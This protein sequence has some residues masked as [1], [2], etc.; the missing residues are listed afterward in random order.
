VSIVERAL[1]TTLSRTGSAVPRLV[2]GGGPARRRRI[3]FGLILPVALVILWEAACRVGFIAPNQ[4]PAPTAVLQDMAAMAA[5]GELFDHIGITLYRVFV[6]FLLGVAAATVLGSLTGY[7]R[8][9]RELLDPL[10]QAL[11]NVPSLAWVPLFILWLGIYELSKVTLI[12]AGV[13]F[14]VYLNLMSGIQGVDRKLV[15]VGRVYR[16]SGLKLIRRVL[17]PATLPSYLVGLRSGLGL[18]WMF[19]IAAEL[20]GA[21]KGLG[22][23]LLDGQMTSRPQPIIGSIVLFALFGKLSDI[24]LVAVGNRFVVWQD[25]FKTQGEGEEARDAAH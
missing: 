19:V 18:G 7:S 22:F 3:V 12:A 15:E 6:G 1:S 4:L 10:V 8:L 21:S 23:L 14:P 5:T 25:T 17:L 2:R 20:M 13:F 24:V 16:L 9:C 11:R